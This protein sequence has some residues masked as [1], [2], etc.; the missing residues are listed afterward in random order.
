MIESVEICE[1]FVPVRLY[2]YKKQSAPPYAQQLSTTFEISVD[3][4]GISHMAEPF[5]PLCSE[6]ETYSMSQILWP[7]HKTT[8]G[9]Q[10]Y[11]PPLSA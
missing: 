8:V 7:K 9:L 1:L 5:R 3:F 10:K 4:V 2:L 11:L 6:W